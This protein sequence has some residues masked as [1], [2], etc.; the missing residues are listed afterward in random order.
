ML[1]DGA[2][3]A[4]ADNQR[5]YRQARWL[6]GGYATV[7][8]ALVLVLLLARVRSADARLARHLSPDGT[9]AK[10]PPAAQRF[11]LAFIVA[12]LCVSLGFLL[13]LLVALYRIGVP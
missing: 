7:S 3:Q 5:V 4:Y 8:L 13:V 2:P 12:V 11:G 10:R 1:L 6:A 9:L